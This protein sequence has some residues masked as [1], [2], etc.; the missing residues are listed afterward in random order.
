M[1]HVETGYPERQ[2]DDAVEKLHSGQGA[3]ALVSAENGLQAWLE[4]FED[5]DPFT[6]DMARALS[7]HAQVLHCW[8]DPDLAVAAADLAI[9]TFLNRRDEINRTASARRRHVPAFLTSSPS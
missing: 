9:R 7:Q 8:G 2:L 6:V 5:D 4:R 3:S 1:S